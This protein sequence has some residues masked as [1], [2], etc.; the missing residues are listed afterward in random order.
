MDDA[1]AIIRAG[2]AM[3]EAEGLKI[4]LAVVEPS[5]ELVAFVRM[6][7]AI[8]GSIYA[9]PAKARTAAR[10]RVATA[11]R[12]QQL[13]GGRLPIL[14]NDEVMAI[15]GGVP[16]VREGKVVGAVG[17]SG[18]TA[19]QDAMMASAIAANP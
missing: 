15:G 5:G 8:Y 13:M 14:S 2:L 7:G 17:V 19:D 4:S 3:A 1:Q 6:D 12:E 18:G 16:I 9:A 10:Y 11:S